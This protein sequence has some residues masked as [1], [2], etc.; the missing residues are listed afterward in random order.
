MNIVQY[1][2]LKFDA[3]EQALM[4]CRDK[5]R[6]PSYDASPALR[7]SVCQRARRTSYGMAES[8]NKPPDDRSHRT[9]SPKVSD[10]VGTIWPAKPLLPVT[11]Y[12]RAGK[13]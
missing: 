13:F 5:Q 7:A 8:I 1:P 11:L 3:S 10:L 9:R 4:D 6:C 2:V 12:A